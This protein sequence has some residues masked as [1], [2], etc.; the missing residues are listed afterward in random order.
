VQEALAQLPWYH[1]I[2]VYW[3]SW[4]KEDRVCYAKKKS[5]KTIDALM[6]NCWRGGLILL[7]ICYGFGNLG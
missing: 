1:H 6:E 3:I 2:V 4:E 5:L 7:V